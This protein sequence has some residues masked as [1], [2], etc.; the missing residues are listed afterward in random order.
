MGPG[1]RRDDVDG[2]GLHPVCAARKAS[3]HA[4]RCIVFASLFCL[5]GC[6]WQ[7]FVH[8][9]V[10]VEPYRLV[11]VD[12]F[13]DMSLCR[14]IDKSGACV[15]DGLPGPTVFQA[16]VNSR[17]IVLARH[18]CELGG[19]PDRSVTEFY[20]IAL[21]AKDWQPGD[22]R[23]TKFPVMGPFNEIEYQRE[24]TRLQLPEFTRVF[25]K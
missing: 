11:A 6:G 1:L 18:P 21:S 14:S 8:D 16:G 13:D 25:G 4:V 23:N 2:E 5:A 7:D 22:Q 12:T 10:L 20:V 17:Y 24:K 3:S 19:P 15:G 9:E